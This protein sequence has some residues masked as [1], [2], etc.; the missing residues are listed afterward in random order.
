[1][2]DSIEE[3][4]ELIHVSYISSSSNTDGK[5]T[6]EENYSILFTYGVWC[7]VGLVQLQMCFTLV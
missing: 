5:E 4:I 1:M 6:E 7:P 2:F 3:T